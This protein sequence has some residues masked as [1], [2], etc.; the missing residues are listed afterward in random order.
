[1]VVDSTTSPNHTAFER[2]KTFQ[3]SFKERWNRPALAPAYDLRAARSKHSCNR[4]CGGR[5]NLRI[6]CNEPCAI[7]A[8]FD[9]DWLVE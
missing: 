8:L 1:M 9:N 4:I 5:K 6:D 3:C 2:R 7:V